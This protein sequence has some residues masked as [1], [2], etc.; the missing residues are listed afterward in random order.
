MSETS[1]DRFVGKASDKLQV[2]FPDGTITEGKQ[3]VKAGTRAIVEN[4][5]LKGF[6]RNDS[7]G[8]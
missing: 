5:E 7:K 6:K 8:S 1:R 4:G 3:V 2:E